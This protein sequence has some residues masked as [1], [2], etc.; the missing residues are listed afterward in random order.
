MS[1]NPD[2]PDIVDELR[3]KRGV[4]Y[5]QDVLEFLHRL[6]KKPLFDL[7]VTSPPYDIGKA[8]EKKRM[9]LEA[10]KEW[11]REVI[12]EIVDRMTPNGSICWQVGNHLDK[13]GAVY[14]LDIE[15]API[16]YDKGLTL[17][18]RIVWHF[19]HG[20][21]AQRRFSGRYEVILWFTKGDDYIFNL[22]AVRVPSKYP[23]K[24]SFKPG[25][26]HGELSGNPKGKNPEDVWD[27]PNVVGNHQEKT[28]H[29][30][31]YPVGIV[32]RLVRALTNQGGIVFDPFTGSGS[33]AVAAL[34]RERYFIGT[35]K[36]P[37]YVE[38]AKTRIANTLNGTEKFRP[39]EKP[40][41]DHTKSKLSK[42]P[43]SK[44]WREK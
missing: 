43:S 31:Q 11:Q 12:T 41:Y 38:I 37:E 26:G 30:C 2:E 27:V 44:E 28:A 34:C 15:L 8:Y 35:E 36:V 13:K 7:V 23:G 42:F 40:I 9:S 33:T 4:V 19:G 20:L 21:H 24:R 29:P 6:P 18:N 10:Y 5:Q 1:K 17:R 22:D 39:I 25:K 32:D 3:Q 14:P 16:F